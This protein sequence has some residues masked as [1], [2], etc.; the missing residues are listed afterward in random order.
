MR[1]G[2]R[3]STDGNR[4][5]RD[6]QVHWPQGKSSSWDFAGQSCLLSS[7]EFSLKKA[8]NSL[9]H[10]EALISLPIN[11]FFC[12]FWPFD[13]GTWHLEVFW[14]I[15]CPWARLQAFLAWHLKWVT[16]IFPSSWLLVS[17]SLWL[18]AL[19]AGTPATAM[20]P[21]F[22]IERFHSLLAAVLWSVMTWGTSESSCTFGKNDCS[23][24]SGFPVR[25]FS[26]NGKLS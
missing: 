23:L 1:E 17:L 24:F 6:P 5:L 13:V 9:I 2:N 16:F 7:H 8:W 20:E 11:Y 10:S 22:A 21:P 26:F 15:C 4:L 18:W 25:S 12:F 19:P 3:T 14:G